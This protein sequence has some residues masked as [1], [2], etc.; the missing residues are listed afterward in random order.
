MTYTLVYGSAAQSARDALSPAL[1]EELEEGLTKLLQ[2]PKVASPDPAGHR[3]GFVSPRLCIIYVVSDVCD[4]VAVF[5]LEE[6]K[7]PVPDGDITRLV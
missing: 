3:M 4:E 1:K 6:A 5:W 7:Q 2:N